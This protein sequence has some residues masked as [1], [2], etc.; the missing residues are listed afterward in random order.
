M[1]P[2]Q[3][4]AV[5]LKKCASLL[6]DTGVGFI[7]L[8]TRK[9]FYVD[10]YE[11]YLQIFK[12]GKGEGFTSAED[13]IESLDECGIQHQIHRIFYEEPIK[14]DDHAALEHYIKHEATVNC[15]NK[16]KET[17]QLSE[18]HEITLEE[19]LSYPEMEQYLNSL[20]RNSVYYFPEEVLLI[21]F[22]AN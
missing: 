14:A 7:A 4:L 11:Q 22:N 1:I 13:V 20:L 16:D 3:D 2:R 10:F 8:A 5:V 17:E 18:S 12:E 15:F 6:K 21:S 9:S 19:L